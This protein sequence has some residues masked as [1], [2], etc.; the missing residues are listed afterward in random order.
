M[1]KIKLMIATMLS[2]IAL[3]FAAVFS[4][5]VNA[6]SGVNITFPYNASE[7]TNSSYTKNVEAFGDSNLGILTYALDNEV[8]TAVAIGTY[9]KGFSTTSNTSDKK[10]VKFTNKNTSAS[11]DVNVMV[12][13]CDSSSPR[14]FYS[15]TATFGTNTVTTSTSNAVSIS[16]RIS[17]SSD[18]ILYINSR[19]VVIYSISYDVVSSNNYSATFSLN[20]GTG[21]APSDIV[22]SKNADDKTITLPSTSATKAGYLFA[23]WSN[24]DS[25]DSNNPY[26]AGDS[27]ELT[28]DTT[29]TAVWSINLTPISSEWYYEFTSATGNGEEIL[30]EGGTLYSGSSLKMQAATHIYFKT[31]KKFKIRFTFD[32][33]Q[34]SNG[35][36]INNVKKT[37]DSTTFT[38]EDFFEAGDFEIT[39]ADGEDRLIRIDFIDPIADDATISVDAE[40]NS[41]S[42]ELRFITTLEGVELSKVQ[43][44]ELVLWKDSVA[45][46][47]KNKGHLLMTSVYSSI[48]NADPSSSYA[49]GTNIYY[50]IVKISDADNFVGSITT[51][52]FNT[53]VTYTDGSTASMATAKSFAVSQLQ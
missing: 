36:K 19:R 8:S 41:D 30:V 6:A 50:G 35:F 14:K 28:K 15:T 5:S 40:K 34:I 11:I 24:G 10:Y 21:T 3:V 20:G 43:S 38:F 32:D 49:G 47:N 12:A 22:V 13:A 37:I 33:Y 26:S 48:S 23:G 25:N 4:V 31:S 27:Y 17:P 39:R 29:F 42:T 16:S 1:K 7:D 53:I 18:V 46:S 44:I 52:Y 45:D 51:I 9:T 2:A